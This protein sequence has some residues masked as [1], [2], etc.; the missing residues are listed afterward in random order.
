MELLAKVKAGTLPADLI[1]PGDRQLLV[2]VLLADGFSTAEIAEVLKFSDRTIERDRRAIREGMAV[3]KDPKLVE[4]MVGKLIAEAE[5]STQRIRRT[6]RERDVDASVKIDA[7]HRCF[8]IHRELMQFLQ[9][10]GYLPTASQKVEADLTHHL[11]ELP[12]F[13]EMRLEVDRIKAV[14]GGAP[15]QFAEIDDVF[16]RVAVA[17]QVKQLATTLN[18][19]GESDANGT[20]S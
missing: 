2:A 12:S 1:A 11:G 16:A 18:N 14:S 4:Q 19:T 8:E 6:A 9:R 5:L 7:Q 3:P 17:S 10:V 13:D 15:D 20:E